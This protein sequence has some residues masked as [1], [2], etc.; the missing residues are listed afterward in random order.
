MLRCNATFQ[1]D[2]RT[3]TGFAYECLS[4]K[5]RLF[6]V[7]GVLGSGIVAGGSGHD[8]LVRVYRDT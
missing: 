4:G 2:T 6:V 5:P 3:N 7:G 8:V 1:K